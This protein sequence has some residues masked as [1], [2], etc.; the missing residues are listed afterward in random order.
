MFIN[1]IQNLSLIF[2][3]EKKLF[4]LFSGIFLILSDPNQNHQFIFSYDSL[5]KF[6]YMN[7][8]SFHKKK[9]MSMNGNV[10]INIINTRNFR[11]LFFLF[12]I[13]RYNILIYIIYVFETKSN[14]I[15]YIFNSILNLDFFKI[16][17]FFMQMS[18]NIIK[19]NSSNKNI[20]KKNF[21]QNI[22]FCIFIIHQIFI[23]K[24]CFYFL[25]IHFTLGIISYLLMN[26]TES[27]NKGMIRRVFSSSI[28]LR[29]DNGIDQEEE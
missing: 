4:N 20:Q 23:A 6:N 16:A 8:I 10:F 7:L 27:E 2:I 25:I 17:H 3:E 19:G 11:E 13:I 9:N 1:L 5:F 21:T 26:D 12:N 28:N 24:E 14:G 18:L 29:R 22:I 15:S